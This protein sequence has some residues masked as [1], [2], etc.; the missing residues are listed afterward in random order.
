[1]DEFDDTAQYGNDHDGYQDEEEA[2][3]HDLDEEDVE[4]QKMEDALY[5]SDDEEESPSEDEFQEDG[6][7]GLEKEQEDNVDDFGTKGAKLPK[8]DIPL[9]PGVKIVPD[10]ERKTNPIMTKF[11][12]SYFISQRAI[13]I[14][15]DS[16]LMIPDT[17]F[18]NAIDIAKEETER[19]LNPIIIYRHLPNNTAE[20][21]K[22]SEP[23]SYTHLRAHET[24]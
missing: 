19:K 24:G 23:V 17:Q 22:C 18:V 16:P 2:N 4:A 10:S 15:H 6:V 14:E 1:M 7:L 20:K 21:W 3:G 12:Y 9:A 5:K 13:M 8:K 11:E